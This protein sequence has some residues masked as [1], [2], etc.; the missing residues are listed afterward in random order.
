MK[1]PFCILIAAQLFFSGFGFGLLAQTT[2]HPG[3]PSGRL[4]SPPT[5]R[6]TVVTRETTPAGPGNSFYGTNRT[7][8]L[9]EHFAKLPVT[10]FKTGRWLKKQLELQ[11]DGLTGNLGEISIWLSKKDNAWLTRD[12]KGKY[13]WEELPYWLKGYA[14]IGYMMG[15]EK[16]IKEAELWIDT[17][18]ANQ[19]ESGDFG[20]DVAHDG[21]RDLWTNMPMLWCLQSWYE[22]S[23]DPRVLKFMS[24]YFKWELSIPD[25]HF[26][27]DY[28]EKSRGGD[29]LYSVYWLYNHTGERWLL[30]L[31]TKIDRNT[32]DWRQK[33]NLP[34]WHNVNIAQCFREPATFY[35]QSH[36]PADQDATYNDFKLVPD[37]YVQVPGALSGPDDNAP[38]G[39]DDPRQ[40]IETCG[41]VEQMTS[42]QMLLRSTGDT[43]WADNCEAVAFNTFPA[44]FMPESRSLRYL[45]A[46]TMLSTHSQN[47]ARG[48]ANEV[49]F[50]MR[51]PFSN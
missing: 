19:R 28:W 49:P 22:Y 34:N 16:M 12:G 1:R 6:F 27:K 48:I 33:D 7:P 45:T 25:Q 17:V 11:R 37:I 51:N 44:A 36:L 35:V 43:K 29:N 50:V 42:D 21:N 24:R 23:H 40:A 47:H 13:G 46:P 3:S 14:N 9:K 18:M 4:S 2:G 31:A 30:D 39:Y 32:A 41:M 5:Q 26:L 20:P 15:Y 8:L 38:H 10:A